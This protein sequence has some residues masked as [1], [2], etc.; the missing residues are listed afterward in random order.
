MM[1]PVNEVGKPPRQ[2]R[3]SNQDNPHKSRRHV[4][5]EIGRHHIPFEQDEQLF[6]EQNPLR[7]VGRMVASCKL[8]L[9]RRF[10]HTVTGG[11]HNGTERC[12]AVV[13]KA[14]IVHDHTE[15]AGRAERLVGRIFCFDVPPDAFLP[16]VDTKD[17]LR[18]KSTVLF[19]L[20]RLCIF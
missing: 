14:R 9:R 3:F 11:H 8:I 2:E 7:A 15:E 16:F 1:E 17:Q 12:A 4:D 6:H 13:G 5:D 20:R 18:P 19:Q 10:E